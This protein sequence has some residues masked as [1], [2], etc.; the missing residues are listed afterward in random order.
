MLSIPDAVEIGKI[1]A[2]ETRMGVLVKETD[3]TKQSEVDPAT[4][5]TVEPL[6]VRTRLAA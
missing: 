6:V 2:D 3:L 5:S 1:L 4:E